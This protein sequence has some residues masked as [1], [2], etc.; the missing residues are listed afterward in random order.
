MP[1]TELGHLE[2]K[3]REAEHRASAKVRVERSLDW[4]SG[5]ARSTWSW[6]NCTALLWPDLFI[7][8]GGVTENWASFGDLL[9]SPAE[10]V[11]ARFGND[12]GLIGAAM[13]AAEL[14][15]AAQ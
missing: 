9:S 8:A 1:N 2:V 7:L 13:A 5:R 3:G 10:I 6:R 4:A 12:A 14:A 15:S 11:V